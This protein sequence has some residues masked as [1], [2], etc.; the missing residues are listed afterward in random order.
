MGKSTSKRQRVKIVKHLPLGLSVE[1]GNGEHGIV[2]VRE[3]SWD[4]EK[5]LNWKEHFP[6]GTETWA[7]PIDN[8][9]DRLG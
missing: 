1:L 7:V 4:H 3:I 2:R 9:N 8:E 6:I 5:R